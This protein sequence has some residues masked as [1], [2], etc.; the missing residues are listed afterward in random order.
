VFLKQWAVYRNVLSKLQLAKQ[1]GNR[2][3]PTA[4]RK[5]LAEGAVHARLLEQ[6]EKF[7]EMFAAVGPFPAVSSHKVTSDE[8]EAMTAYAKRVLAWDKKN[9]R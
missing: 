4:S 8:R 7:K 9:N 5:N 6:R 2:S 1:P 3:A